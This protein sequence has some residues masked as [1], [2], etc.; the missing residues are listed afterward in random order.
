MS[1]TSMAIIISSST[2]R[3]R[4]PTSGDVSAIL[5]LQGPPEQAAADERSLWQ[6]AKRDN[7]PPR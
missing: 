7:A 5:E 1:S 4:R 2:T 3:T 6:R